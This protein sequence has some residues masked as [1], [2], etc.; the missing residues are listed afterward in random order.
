MARIATSRWIRWATMLALVCVWCVPLIAQPQPSQILEQYRNQRITWTA[1]IWP[2][3]N[4]LFGILATIEF[5]WSA[6][7]MLLEKNDLQ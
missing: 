1:N 4:T 5:A 6:A 3:A 7:V 2:F